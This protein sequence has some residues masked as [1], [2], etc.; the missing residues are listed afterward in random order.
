MYLN[1]FYGKGG[2]GNT[3]FLPCSRPLHKVIF[4]TYSTLPINC[5]IIV[6]DLIFQLELLKSAT[7]RLQI[8][9]FLTIIALCNAYDP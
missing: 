6:S 3:A 8:N 2:K 7:G 9:L 5:L 4:F 1:V